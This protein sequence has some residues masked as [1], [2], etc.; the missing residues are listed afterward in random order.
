MSVLFA[1]A[2][3]VAAQPTRPRHQVSQADLNAMADARHAPRSWLVLKGREIVFLGSP[4]ADFAKIECVLK[5]VSA[6]VPMD[7]ISFIGNAQASEEK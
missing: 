1:L 2:M 7:K 4:D 3:Q 6:V 5:K